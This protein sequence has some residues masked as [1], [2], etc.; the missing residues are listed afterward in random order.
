MVEKFPTPESQEFSEE[1]SRLIRGLKEKGPQD[2]G[3]RKLLNTWLEGEEAK[4]NQINT[5]KANIELNLKRARLYAAAGFTENARENAEGA[6]LQAANEQEP[7]L[8]D[9]A[10][11]IIDKIEKRD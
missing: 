2:E 6:M 8:W 4:T 11:S 3:T 5:P 10:R 9:K 7:G 1:E